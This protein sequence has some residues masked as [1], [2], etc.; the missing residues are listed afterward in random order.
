LGWNPVTSFGDKIKGGAESK[1]QFHFYQGPAFLEPCLAFDIVRQD[2]GEFFAFRPAWP[3]F[4][5]PLRSRH[6]R[7]DFPNT[8]AQAHG[9]FSPN[10]RPKG[11][12]NEGL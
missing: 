8:L 5:W 11:L 3:I 12:G 2:D 9:Q 10:R 6:N 1:I 4:R 7:P